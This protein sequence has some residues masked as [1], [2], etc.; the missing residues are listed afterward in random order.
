MIR[1]KCL[2]FLKLATKTVP[3]LT[4]N[5]GRSSLVS[6]CDHICFQRPGVLRYTMLKGLGQ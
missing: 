1:K 6:C 3:V 4:K 2:W 5:N